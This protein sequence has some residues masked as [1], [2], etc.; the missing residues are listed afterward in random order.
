MHYPVISITLC[1]YN[2]ERYLEEQLDTLVNQ[3]YENLEIII[4]DDCSVDS[5][6]HI[7]RQYENKDKRI[8]LY[9]N[10]KNLGYVKNFEKALSL[11]TGEYIAIS[12][13][14]DIWSLE[15]IRLQYEAMKDNLLVYH[16]SQLVSGDGSNLNRS[17]SDIINMYSGNNPKVFLLHNSVSG[18]AIMMKRAILQ[19]AF[20]F[21]PNH[22]YDHWLAY[23]ATT[24][25]NVFYFSE[26]LVKY[27]QHG[28]NETDILKSKKPKRGSKKKT[29]STFV[30]QGEWVSYC[31]NH[32]KGQYAGDI[33]KLCESYTKRLHTFVSFRY[34]FELFKNRE[35]IFFITKKS[36]WSVLNYLI[37]QIWGE[38]TKRLLA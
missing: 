13:Q 35:Y 8:A 26:C 33:I 6:M 4:V 11:C 18:H 31:A 3:T 29:I 30:R 9:Q 14:D 34:A 2:G 12:D 1:T 37:K 32:T 21:P 36:K 20:P 24:L 28:L 38:R 23:I 17:V 5:T 15:K 16:N 19:A 7:L 10:E 27:R 22:P 25:G